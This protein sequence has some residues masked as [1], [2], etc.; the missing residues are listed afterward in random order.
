M[1][2]EPPTLT[3]HICGDI[4]E[5]VMSETIS[6]TEEAKPGSA[7]ASVPSKE[8]SLLGWFSSIKFLAA[9]A[10]VFAGIW[11]LFPSYYTQGYLDTLN[12]PTTYFPVEA[13][14]TPATF[15]AS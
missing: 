15:I 12:V 6:G 13:A 10:G 8:V 5:D 1:S 2:Y 7:A 4:K 11:A 14:D 3:L 9:V